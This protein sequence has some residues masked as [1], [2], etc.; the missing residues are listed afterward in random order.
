MCKLF[1][2]CS[3]NQKPLDLLIPYLNSSFEFKML[4]F[5]QIWKTLENHSNWIQNRYGKSSK[6]ALYQPN[7]IY[8]ILATGLTNLIKV[9]KT[10]KTTANTHVAC[11]KRWFFVVK[12]IFKVYEL[13]KFIKYSIGFMLVG[14]VKQN[15]KIIISCESWNIFTW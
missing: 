7:Q 9:G 5:S 15:K 8:Q 12:V 13:H 11:W 6:I 3:I 14:V 2:V 4:K 1:R 10:F